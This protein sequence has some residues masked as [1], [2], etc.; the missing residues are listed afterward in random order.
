MS[1]WN[2]LIVKHYKST[3]NNDQIITLKVRLL[4]KL[5]LEEGLKLSLIHI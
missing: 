5:V 4:M 2:K 1:Y 3:L